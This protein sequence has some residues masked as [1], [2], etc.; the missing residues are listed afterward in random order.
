VD[1]VLTPKFGKSVNLA[2]HSP[3]CQN[4]VEIGL[5]GQDLQTDRERKIKSAQN[6]PSMSHISWKFLEANSLY[7]TRIRLRPEFKN[8][9]DDGSGLRSIGT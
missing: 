3:I 1:G 2:T 6:Y 7:A 9:E 5:S 8:M 4:Y